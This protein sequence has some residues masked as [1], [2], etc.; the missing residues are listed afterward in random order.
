M[1]DAAAYIFST[2]KMPLLC[3]VESIKHTVVILN[4]DDYNQ[5]L[6]SAEDAGNSEDICGFIRDGDLHLNGVP[7]E[8]HWSNE[9]IAANP[10]TFMIII[11]GPPTCVDSL[12]EMYISMERDWYH[13]HDSYDI[14]QTRVGHV[15]VC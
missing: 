4:E 11:K 13:Q 15:A 14:W 3:S 10:G 2:A 12:L 8:D 1:K 9:I 5:I 6:A 7:I